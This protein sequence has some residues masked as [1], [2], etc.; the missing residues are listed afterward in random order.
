MACIFPALFEDDGLDNCRDIPLGL[1]HLLATSSACI[2]RS[3]SMQPLLRMIKC[4]GAGG[5]GCQGACP[6]RGVGLWW[7]VAVP[8]PDPR[9]DRLPGSWRPARTPCLVLTSLP[10]AARR[11]RCRLRR[12]LRGAE[13]LEAQLEPLFAAGLMVVLDGATLAAM[14]PTQLDRVGGFAGGWLGAWCRLPACPPAPQAALHS[15]CPER[16]LPKPAGLPPMGLLQILARVG[17][18]AG[19]CRVPNCRW[20]VV[21][22]PADLAALQQAAQRSEQPAADNWQRWQAWQASGRTRQLTA[23]EVGGAAAAPGAGNPGE[24]PL[25]PALRHALQAAKAH[26]T[27]CRLVYLCSNDPGGH[28]SSAAWLFAAACEGRCLCG[29]A[30]QAAAH[31]SAPCWRPTPLCAA[32]EV[33]RQ[34]DA[35]LSILSGSVQDLL[36]DEKKAGFC[37]QDAQAT[38]NLLGPEAPGEAGAA[39]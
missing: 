4:G 13:W 25:A 29:T 39:E 35:R 11:A 32:A 16:A 6:P 26:T 8:N 19:A 9:S 23:L 20:E 30:A 21:A 12:C 34:A 10:P 27:S 18:L 3:P 2:Y 5:R 28:A 15:A 14:Q 36:W 7:G 22:S 17:E 33:L 38:R 31:T 24:P 1:A 37:L